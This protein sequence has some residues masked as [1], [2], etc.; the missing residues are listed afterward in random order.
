MNTYAV[1]RWFKYLC[2]ISVV[3]GI[4]LLLASLAFLANGP[5]SAFFWLLVVGIL[6]IL[7]CCVADCALVHEKNGPYAPGSNWT[8]RMV[9]RCCSC[10]WCGW[11]IQ[12]GNE[13]ARE[14]ATLGGTDAQGEAAV[15]FAQVVDVSKLRI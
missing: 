8:W 10:A 1:P 4:V 13:Q 14:G 15:P 2:V 9:T 7:C 5:E 11:M 3:A 12:K 6:L